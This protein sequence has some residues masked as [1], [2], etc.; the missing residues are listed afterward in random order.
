MSKL[1]KKSKKSKDATTKLVIV[2]IYTSIITVR[3]V[4]DVSRNIRIAVLRSR[5]T[6][7][8]SSNILN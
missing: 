2:T 5:M 3:N 1:V 7:T 8:I 6:I 4:V